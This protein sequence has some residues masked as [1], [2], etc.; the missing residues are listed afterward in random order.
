MMIAGSGWLVSA[1]FGALPL[2]LAAYLT[3]EAVAQGL[4][5]PGQTYVSSLVYFRN[6]LHDLFESMSAWTTTGLSMAVHEPSI[7]NGLLFDRSLAQWIEGAGVIVLALA[8]IPRPDI[9]GELEPYQSEATGVKLRPRILGAARAI[10][11]VYTFLTLVMTANLFVATLV[12]LSD[13]G[14]WPS[15]F[16]ALSHAMALQSTGGFRGLDDSIAGY[17]SYPLAMAHSPPM[18]VA[19]DSCSSSLLAFDLHSK[20]VAQPIELRDLARAYGHCRNH[21]R[22]KQSLAELERTS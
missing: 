14:V 20:A 9:A 10:R 16:D 5:P 11:K 13:C 6:P 12:F 18:V 21:R 8:I 2:L 3:P 15:L 7:G 1:A 19:A 17:R 22:T 4:V